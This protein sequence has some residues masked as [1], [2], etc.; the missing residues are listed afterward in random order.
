MAQ[1]VAPAEPARP[2]GAKGDHSLTTGALRDAG[3]SRMMV[4]K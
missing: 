3:R 2:R 1:S 4:M